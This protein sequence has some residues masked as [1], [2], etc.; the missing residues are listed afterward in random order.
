[1]FETLTDADVLLNVARQRDL[2]VPDALSA[3]IAAAHRLEELRH[4]SGYSADA[5]LERF[6]ASDGTEEA[7]NSILDDNAARHARGQAAAE[8]YR[9]AEPEALRMFVRA[10]SSDAGDE[11]AATLNGVLAPLVDTLGDYARLLPPGLNAA[12]AL[13]AGDDTVKAW[14]DGPRLAAEINQLIGPY[15][16]QIGTRFD[17][18]EQTRVTWPTMPQALLVA[19]GTHLLPAA[20][21]FSG[22]G[23]AGDR[24]GQPGMLLRANGLKLRSVRQAIELWDETQ[25]N[26][27]AQQAEAEAV[28][29]ATLNERRPNNTQLGGGPR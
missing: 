1:M 15:V 13:D 24:L 6:M 25:G 7:L 18:L 2:P 3:P 11:L 19:G 12:Q 5:T 20:R 10:L 14:I 8:L 21:T 26:I 29:Q 23:T 22:A 28:A 17:L 4:Q 16:Q 27:R 9:L